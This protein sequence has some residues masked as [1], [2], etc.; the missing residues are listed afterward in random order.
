MPETVEPG[1]AR[2]L[3]ALGATVDVGGAATPRRSAPAWRARRDSGALLMHAYDQLEVVAGAGTLAAEIEDEAGLPDRVLVSVG[4][5]GLIAGVAAWFARPLPRR[6]ARAASWRRRCT[7]RAS[8]G[9]PVDVDGRPASPP[10]RSARAASAAS[11]G[12]SASATSPRRTCSPTTPSAPRSW[13][14]WREL[15]LAVEPA[16]ALPLAAL[17]T[18]RRRAASRR[19]RAAGGLRR[20]RR[21]G[22]ARRLAA[23]RPSRAGRAERAV[24]SITADVVVVGLGAVGSATCHHLARRGARV[25][26][27]DRFAPP[28]DHGSSH[29]LS[30]VT[31]LAVGEGEAYV[32]LALRSH[33]LWR[34]LEA[35]TGES[36]YRP[37]GGPDRLVR[38]RRCDA[39][40]RQRRL[41]RTHPSDRPRLRDRTRAAGRAGDP[42]A[43]SGVRRPRRRIRLLRADR[44]RAVS[45]A[46]RGGAARRGET[47]R[48]RPAPERKGP[49]L[50]ACRIDAVTVVTDRGRLSAA[51]VVVA[52]G[53]WTA[54]LDAGLAPG[55]LRV[56]RQA[57]FWFRTTQPALYR[58]QGLPDLHLDARRAPRRRAVRFSD[59]RRRRR[60]Q[61]RRRAVRRRNRPGPGRPPCRARGSDRPCSIATSPAA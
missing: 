1:Q 52:A 28:H 22:I 20:Q 60:R 13:R 49:A 34:E 43:L 46:R 18:G 21:R 42:R 25:V 50:R 24:T 11:P 16:A 15:R 10:T 8:A 27:I 30:R 32:P 9:E 19:A 53:P 61:D 3:A 6:G 29:G 38:P 57:L 35:Q 54:G 47:A 37:T 7:R 31:R 23:P 26:G 40:P 44:R 41:L 5:G 51:R 48:R 45:G 55:A 33:E 58:P 56:Q 2:R 39:V 14:M 17:A 59:D 12:R 4:G 36:I